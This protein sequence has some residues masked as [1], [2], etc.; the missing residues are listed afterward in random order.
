MRRARSFSLANTR[1]TPTTT[2]TPQTATVFVSR[3]RQLAVLERRQMDALFERHSDATGWDRGREGFFPL[4][5][6]VLLKQKMQ[7][8]LWRSSLK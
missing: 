8:E 1:R 7:I 4:I 2:T 3:V 5:F 6:L